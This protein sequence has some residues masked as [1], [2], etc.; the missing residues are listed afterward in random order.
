[1]TKRIRPSKTEVHK[2]S[3]KYFDHV[4]S[5]AQKN[6]SCKERKVVKDAY[7]RI[8][9]ECKERQL[10]GS[11]LN[12]QM[13]ELFPTIYASLLRE[14]NRIYGNVESGIPARAWFLFGLGQYPKCAICKSPTLS[15]HK[16]FIS[17]DTPILCSRA[18]A[19]EYALRKA[20]EKTIKKHG[21][22][23]FFM[24]KEFQD[25]R[26]KYLQQRYG[27][28]VTGPTLVPGAAEKIE[29]TSLQHFGVTHFARAQSVKDKKAKTNVKRYGAITVLRT[30]DVRQKV[31]DIC[32]E[33]YGVEHPSKAKIIKDKKRQTQKEKKSQMVTN[34][35]LTMLAKYGANS[36]YSIKD[37][38][39][40]LCSLKRKFT[41]FRGRVIQ[42]YGYENVFIDF[43]QRFNNIKSVTTDKNKIPV[44]PYTFKKKDHEYFP[45]ILVTLTNGE[46]IVVEVK[47]TWTLTMQGKASRKNNAKFKQA[48]THLK[49]L[50][51][52]F[53]VALI[54]PNKQIRLASKN[55]T[56]TNLLYTNDSHFVGKIYSLDVT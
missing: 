56:V 31:K 29:R 43:L 36:L 18:C 19:A 4:I 34:Q 2:M 3:C 10:T 7:A 45:D 51:Y 50:G 11:Y 24:S 22:P 9:Q 5:I 23:N 14:K 38:I 17:Y 25:N 49:E 32:L 21:V 12:K 35:R 16:T 26:I 20:Q 54:K 48:A 13:K 8:Y 42:C 53:A 37:V 46:R 55:L 28:E 39:K 52:Q 6:Y 30:K 41:T 27:Q 44:I 47:S 1:M 15:I 33:K 40:P